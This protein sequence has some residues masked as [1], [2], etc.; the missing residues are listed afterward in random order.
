MV[1]M[2]GKERDQK[3][4]KSLRETFINKYSDKKNFEMLLEG[5]DENYLDRLIHLLKVET[6]VDIF[7]DYV[8]L[9]EIARSVRESKQSDV[10]DEVCAVDEAREWINDNGKYTTL[11]FGALYRVY[12]RDEALKPLIGE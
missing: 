9:K 5:L 3:L 2:K 12:R 1:M 7:K 8:E 10:F 4:A 6:K 11:T